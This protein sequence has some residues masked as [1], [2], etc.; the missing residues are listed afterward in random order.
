MNELIVIEKSVFMKDENVYT[1]SLDVANVFSKRHD[2]VLNAIKTYKND[3]SMVEFTHPNFRL[4]RYQDNSGRYN[5]CYNLTKDG[6]VF[7]V[8]GFT[9]S[10]ANKFKIAYINRF[11]EME[12]CLVPRSDLKVNYR[13]SCGVLAQ[14]IRPIKKFTYASCTNFL[15]YLVT[16]STSTELKAFNKRKGIKGSVRDNLSQDHLI[17]LLELEKY[18][19]QLLLSGVDYKLVKKLLYALTQI[20]E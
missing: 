18:R 16:G 9:G 3:E 13:P 5:K 12:K 15:T 10:K 6:L 8:M 20:K 4:S 11:N 7:L 19:E 2:H 17:K 1:T 14:H